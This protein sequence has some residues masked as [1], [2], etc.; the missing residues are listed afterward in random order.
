MTSMKEGRVHYSGPAEVED[1]GHA[2]MIEMIVAKGS[3]LDMEKTEQDVLDDLL[4]RSKHS[5]GECE[6]VVRTVG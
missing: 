3:V 4:D 5:V 1:E 2:E 6:E